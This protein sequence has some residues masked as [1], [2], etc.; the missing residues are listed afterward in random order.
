MNNLVI[1]IGCGRTELNYRISFFG[2]D[3]HIHIDGGSSHLGS[4]SA[5]QN[6][7]VNTITF[8][9]HKEHLLTDPLAKKLSM[10]FSGN[11]MVSAGVHLDIITKQEINEILENNERAFIE[12][13][14]VLQERVVL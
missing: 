11:V 8:P 6:G 2:N 7:K 9:E 1:K 12:I 10:R 14:H 3:L 5:A 4:I 13:I